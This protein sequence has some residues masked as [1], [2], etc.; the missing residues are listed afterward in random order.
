[1][2]NRE[3]AGA[4]AAKR[5]TR[6]AAGW[7]FVGLGA[8]GA[9][10]PLL[11]ATPFLLL[12]ALCFA[13]SSPRYYRHLTRYAWVK[14]Y[15]DNYRFGC[16]V[17]RKTK[18]LSLLF[19]WA[20]LWASSLLREA[21]LYQVI[22]LLV[23]LGV[24][25]HL[26]S[27]RSRPAAGAP[28]GPRRR[29]RK[30]RPVA[31]TAEARALLEQAPAFVAKFAGPAAEREARKRG[32][33]SVTAELLRDLAGSRAGRKRPDE[34]FRFAHCFARPGDRPLYE[35]FGPETLTNDHGSRLAAGL[36]PA[37]YAAAWDRALA[38]LPAET[39]KALYVHIPFCSTRCKYCGFFV[40][41]S[42]PGALDRYTD[43]LI[44]ELEF[45]RNSGGGDGH[46]YHSLYLG[47]GTPSDLDA[48]NLERLLK[49]LR[50][51]RFAADA[52]LTLEGRLS[53]LS[54]EKVSICAD[55][56]INRFSLGVQ[57]FDTG[58]R[59][60]M[61]RISSREEVIDGLRQLA[62]RDRFAV[63]I[64]LLYGLPGQS[65]ARW[66][67]DLRTLFEACPV[68]GV[69]HYPLIRMPGTPLDRAVAAGELPP[70]PDAA[71]RADMFVRGLELMEH[72]G[73]RRIALKHFAMDDRER[74]RYNRLQAFH[75]DCVP[76]GSGS[77]GTF[78][79]FS[80]YQGGGLERYYALLGEGRKPLTMVA[81]LDPDRAVADR[82]AGSILI[83]RAFDPAAIRAAAGP[84]TP[85]LAAL[86]RPLLEQYE[87]CGLV[88]RRPDGAVELTV[89]GQFWHNA[90]I[91]NLKLVFRQARDA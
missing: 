65:M 55:Y 28:P 86:W 59:R 69:D 46:T 16:G 39:E 45:I 49:A 90:I 19:L 75:G 1:M 82:L 52:E 42:R 6:L 7:I 83:D 43:A 25:I 5:R 62:A 77:G 38:Q 71:G 40:N 44:R 35:A 80:F 18:L 36:E 2:R 88:R 61:G 68:S 51:F 84:D 8:A 67:E 85:D 22:L 64:D 31:W 10:L 33:S 34:P 15:L 24:S 3:K 81:P 32:E 30:R 73:A 53:S 63:V 58:L 87:S 56:G 4:R 74:N 89:P 79:G 12:A 48:P 26:L 70:L 11:P 66:E 57:T 20:A 72:Y 76:A 37:G 54:P 50:R 78:G 60:A 13:G 9:A 47:G 91:Q 14:S 27:L 21:L 41:G 29:R 23:G 17:P